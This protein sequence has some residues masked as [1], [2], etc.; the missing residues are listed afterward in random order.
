MFFSDEE[1]GD[2]IIFSHEDKIKN[3]TFILKMRSLL[4]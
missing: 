1:P 2:E 4:S 3:E